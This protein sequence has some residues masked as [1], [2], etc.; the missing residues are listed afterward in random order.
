MKRIIEM[1]KKKVK[2]F[3]C[4]C[5]CV[6]ESDEYQRHVSGEKAYRIDYCPKCDAIGNIKSR[7][8]K[9]DTDD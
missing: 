8:P 6:W 3:Q 1:L 7:P 5:G 2:L 9:E 4:R